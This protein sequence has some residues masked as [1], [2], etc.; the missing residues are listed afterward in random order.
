MD[1]REFI[2]NILLQNYNDSIVEDILK[3]YKSKYRCSS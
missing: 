2:K 3:G 1:N